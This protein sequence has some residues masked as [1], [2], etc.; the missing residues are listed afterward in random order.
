ML[1]GRLAEN[2]SRRL[3]QQGRCLPAPCG[4]FIVPHVHFFILFF[5]FSINLSGRKISLDNMHTTM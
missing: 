4:F 1:A 2:I 3:K 5:S